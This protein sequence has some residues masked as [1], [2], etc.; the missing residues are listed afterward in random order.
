MKKKLYWL[1]IILM[2]FSCIPFEDEYEDEDDNA[3]P[4]HAKVAWVSDT[5]SNACFYGMRK[6][7]HLYVYDAK[8]TVGK[9]YS[10]T[11]SNFRLVKIDLDTGEVIWK[12]QNISGAPPECAPAL[13]ADKWFVFTRSTIYCFDANDGSL[14]AIMQID[15][16]DRQYRINWSITAYGNFLYFGFGRT[17]TEYLARLNVIDSINYNNGQDVQLLFPEILWESRYNS[18]V[19]P[20]L[21][22]KDSIIYFM[23]YTW[24]NRKPLELTAMDLNSGEIVW[25]KL[26]DD[27][28]GSGR[29]FLHDDTIFMM[30]NTV[31]A[32]NIL[33]GERIYYRFFPTIF[34]I[35]IIIRQVHPEGL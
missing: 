6:D 30:T 7:N 4:Y 24:V 28:T 32:Y 17:D 20:P 18:R 14:L 29:L 21:E 22:I 1:L 8:I 11:S 3:P 27:D 5:G 13:A 31:S 12:S 16:E 33:N 25:E 9:D 15:D 10:L 35:M 34:G 19:R 23:T 2:F 26:I